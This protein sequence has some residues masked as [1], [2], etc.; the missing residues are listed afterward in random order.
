MDNNNEQL[1]SELN[2]Q[3]QCSRVFNLLPKYTF[4]TADNNYD[5]PLLF[6]KNEMNLQKN[7]SICQLS[8]LM[9]REYFLLLKCK[10]AA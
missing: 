9:V 10:Y 4:M 6:C 1:N 8:L 3:I 7:K 5:M 2:W